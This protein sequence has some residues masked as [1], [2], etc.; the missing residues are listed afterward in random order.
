MVKLEP[1]DST[2]AGRPVNR[3]GSTRSEQLKS[4]LEAWWRHYNQSAPQRPGI[5][6][7]GP[8]NDRPLKTLATQF[9]S[10]SPSVVEH[11]S[12]REHANWTTRRGGWTA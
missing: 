9:C 1:P 5:S 11:P 2:E 8:G 4:W 6:A 3:T 7:T 12:M 10:P